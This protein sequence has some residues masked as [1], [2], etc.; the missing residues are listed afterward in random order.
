MSTINIVDPGMSLGALTKRKTTTYLILHHSASENTSVEAINDWHRANGWAGIGYNFYIRKNGAIYKGRGW[1]YVGA[2]TIN[3]NSVSIGICFEGNFETADDSM[4][5]VQYNVGVDMIA[6][7]LEKYPTITTICG[8]EKLNATACPGKNFPLDKMI[9]AGW[10]AVGS[11]SSTTSTETNAEETDASSILAGTEKPIATLKA[12]GIKKFQT[13]LNNNYNAGLSV[14]GIY[15]PKTRT[16]AIRAM[17]TNIGTTADGIW[18]SRSN[19]ACPVLGVGSIG[20]DVHILQGMLYCRGSVYAGFDGIFGSMTESE[21]KAYQ[22]ANG[23]L[24]DGKAGKDTFTSLF[25]PIM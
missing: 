11:V 3:Y 17:Q 10:A 8:H 21:I 25:A 4:P 15:G 18:G 9:A 24:V 23:L 7:A 19:A 22:G 5:E 20:N 6:L 16:A 13:W 12:E 1:E 2:H 14:D